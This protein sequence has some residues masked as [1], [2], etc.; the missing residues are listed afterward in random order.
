MT[1]PLPI[2]TI[3]AAVQRPDTPAGNW[4]PCDGRE[5]PVQF[6]ELR[7]LLNAAVTPNL[8][9]RTLIGAGS[10]AAAQNTQT[11][12]LVP[13]FPGLTGNRLVPATNLQ[14]GDTGGEVMHNLTV[15]ELPAHMHTI[16]NGDF[17][18]HQRSFDSS[19][20]ADLPFETGS[21]N[22]LTGTDIT[23]KGISHYNVAPYFAVTYFIL[24][25]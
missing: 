2:G 5:I 11:D 1:F 19:S 13:N 24:A 4:L 3:I 9:G 21:S 12:L 15:D 14:I 25:G 6:T 18:L 23:G 20:D 7:T 16:N 8:I 10:F 22:K 17:G